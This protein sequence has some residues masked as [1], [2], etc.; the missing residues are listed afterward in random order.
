[1]TDEELADLA[2]A[3]TAIQILPA[4]VERGRLHRPVWYRR[5]VCLVRRHRITDYR[6]LAVRIVCATCGATL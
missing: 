4:V 1:M 5:A 2:L 3:T 6:N